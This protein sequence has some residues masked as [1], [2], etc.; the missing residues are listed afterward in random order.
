MEIKTKLQEDLNKKVKES[1]TPKKQL[2]KILRK[3]SLN[4]Q[5]VT[6]KVKKIF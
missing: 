3:M 6:F 1:T 4:S 2:L 5:G